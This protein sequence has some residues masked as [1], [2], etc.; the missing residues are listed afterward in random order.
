MVATAYSLK[1]SYG[2]PERRLRFLTNKL[3]GAK[4]FLSAQLSEKPTLHNYASAEP[5]FLEQEFCY[6]IQQ[7]LR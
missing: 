7:P 1:K 5:F 2:H 4:H 6:A 3:G